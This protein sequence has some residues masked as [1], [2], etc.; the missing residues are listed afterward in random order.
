MRDLN[1]QFEPLSRLMA[2]TQ[3]RLDLIHRLMVLTDPD[4]AQ[5]HAV[6]E[7]QLQHDR[8]EVERTHVAPAEVQPL[9]GDGLQRGG[10]HR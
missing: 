1:A 10:P 3:E 4:L 7:K 5:A 8:R 2:T 9:F 6:V